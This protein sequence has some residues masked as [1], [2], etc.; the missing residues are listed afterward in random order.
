MKLKLL[1]LI[2]AIIKLVVVDA[3]A[4][5]GI[6]F[7]S[8]YFKISMIQ[9]GKTFT[10]VE[11]KV[12]KRKTS[13]AVTFIKNERLYETEAESKKAKFPQ[14][15]FMFIHKFLGALESDKEVFSVSQ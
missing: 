7:G 3:A 10:V 8:Q 1:F 15:T 6:D 5:I 9:P 11:N 13:T 12:S 14:N 2:L 4:V